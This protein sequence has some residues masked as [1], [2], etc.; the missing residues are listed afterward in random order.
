MATMTQPA[1]AAIDDAGALLTAAVKRLKQLLKRLRDTDKNPKT[2]ILSESPPCFTVRFKDLGSNWSPFYHSFQ[3][4]YEALIAL[5]EKTPATGLRQV[6]EGVVAIGRIPGKLDRQGDQLHPGVI[7]Q[8]DAIV[9]PWLTAEQ[10]R[11]I[12]AHPAWSDGRDHS[13]L[14][15]RLDGVVDRE[16]LLRA[17][18][19]WGDNLEGNADCP[20]GKATD[21]ASVRYNLPELLFE[22]N[23]LDPADPGHWIRVDSIC[24]SLTQADAVKVCA[25]DPSKLLE[26]PRFRI[27]ATGLKF[28][29]GWA[30]N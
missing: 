4:Q 12:P 14:F 23:R 6:L 1:M 9:R 22:T 5:I 2:V 25:M 21:D 11:A 18:L 8:L 7:A 16:R 3:L 28:A 24:L 17:E 29:E 13:M 26:V 30:A 15:A 10:L 19:T 27:A 20:D